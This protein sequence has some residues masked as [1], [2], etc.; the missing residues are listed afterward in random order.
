M[1]VTPLDSFRMRVYLAPTG[2]WLTLDAGQFE[3]LELNTKTGAIRVGFASGTQY[4]HTA[5]LRIE[6]PAKVNGAQNYHPA[7]SWKEERGAYIVPLGSGTTWV[8]LVAGP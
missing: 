2:L 8:D 4:L 3:A 1:K 5:R 7:K 6:Q